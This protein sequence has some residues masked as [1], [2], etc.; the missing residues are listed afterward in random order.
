MV[1]LSDK[2]EEPSYQNLTQTILPKIITDFLSEKEEE[3]SDH[4]S[5]QMILLKII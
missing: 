5:T 3:S 1:S 2:E 4:D